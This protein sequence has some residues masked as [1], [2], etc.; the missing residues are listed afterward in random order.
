MSTW[1]TSSGKY[2][3]LAVVGPTAS[4]KS[5]LAMDIARAFNGEIICADSRTIYKGLDIGTAKPS[6]QD[7]QE[8]PHWGIDIVGPGETFTAADFQRYAQSSI[9]DI[10]KRG[11]LPILV[12][13]SGLYV[14]GVIY[15]YTFAPPNES[16]RHELEAYTEEE[17]REKILAAG[18]EL[19]E[20]LHNKRYLIRA[21][22][23]GQSSLGKSSLPEGTVIVGLD[24]HPDVLHQR[25]EQRADLM[26]AAGVEDEVRWAQ[27]EYGKDAQALNGGI[28]K[29]LRPLIDGQVSVDDA[30]RVCIQSDL[31]LAKKQ[32]TWLRRHDEDIHWFSQAEDALGWLK[33]IIIE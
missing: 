8:V 28:Y 30:K 14:D 20:N 10:R 16:L 24:P 23:R 18:L 26:F 19:P 29:A 5:G 15:S 3:L 9:A 31:A 17:L 2:S 27:D 4:G 11:K 21:L 1:Q 6:S 7:R 12:G 32:R 33:S 22:E 25:I 13:G